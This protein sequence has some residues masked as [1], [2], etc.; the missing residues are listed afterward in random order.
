[1]Q[2]GIRKIANINNRPLLFINSC[3]SD[4]NYNELE[5]IVHYAEEEG[6]DG[7]NFNLLWF[8]TQDSIRLHNKSSTFSIEGSSIEVTPSNVNT[9]LLIPVIKAIKTLNT[10][11]IINFIPELDEQELMI[12]YNHPEI[13]LEKRSICGWLRLQIAP[14]GD[15]WQCRELNIGNLGNQSL[16]ELWNCNKYRKFRMEIREKGTFP[17]CN[18]CC[19]VFPSAL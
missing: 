12:Y 16:R 19:Y 8:Q 10:K 6:I 7:I 9:N 3:I 11:L 17:I 5:K 18:R 15:V 13:S 14:N 2:R 4:V 1:M